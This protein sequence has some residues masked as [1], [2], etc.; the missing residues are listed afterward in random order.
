M[1][2][3]KIYAAMMIF[4][5]SNFVENSLISTGGFDI[6]FNDVPV[7]SK[8]EVGRIPNGGELFQIVDNHMKLMNNM[9]TTMHLDHLDHL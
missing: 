8:L 6:Y 9:D 2:T 3:N 1:Q 7:W 5:L 4:F